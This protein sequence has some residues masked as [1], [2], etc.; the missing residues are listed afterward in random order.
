ML[1]H[2]C[3]FALRWEKKTYILRK[4][5][6]INRSKLL[7]DACR[8]FLFSLNPNKP[9]QRHRISQICIQQKI[10]NRDVCA[11]VAAQT[12]WLVNVNHIKQRKRRANRRDS[13]RIC[14]LIRRRW[15][16]QMPFCR[17]SGGRRARTDGASCWLITP[18]AFGNPN[19]VS[20]N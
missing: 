18:T 5:G 11:D 12:W 16:L 14:C 10:S 7:L 1:W 13:S 2:F 4:W 3:L 6:K 19:A 20:V 8:V 15:I 17:R 9:L